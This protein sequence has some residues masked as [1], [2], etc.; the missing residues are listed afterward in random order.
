MALDVVIWQ[1]PGHLRSKAVCRAMLEGV[2]R[3]GDNPRIKP[4]TG[5]IRP[6]GDVAVFY[7]LAGRLA[8]ALADYPKAGKRAVYV[9]LGYWGRKDGGRF[10]GYHKLSVDGRH[11][12]A[13]FQDRP[14]DG[15]RAATFGLKAEP[16]QRRG[17]HILI[18]GMGPK[19]ARAEGYGPL[20][21]EAEAVRLIR[22]HTDRPILYRA[23]PNWLD[24]PPLAGASRS[25]SALPLVDAI[26]S[27]HAVV[28][29][30]SNAAVEAIAAGVPA[31]VVEGAALPMA[32]TDL[33]QIER[34]R[35]PAGRKQWLND[36]AYTQ[37]SIAEMASGV[38][39]RHLKAE[40]RV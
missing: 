2:R 34:P 10:A 13:Y 15:R 3:C 38:A 11:P 25:D 1:I 8:N 27:A 33:S 37:Y 6:D 19:G 18:A 29:H 28:A 35:Y 31:F 23:K 36:L 14:H 7:G 4:A 40:G 39:W 9:D 24:S 17:G 20:G 12:T 21:W 5:Y 32:G 26:R 30:H 22:Q 16:W